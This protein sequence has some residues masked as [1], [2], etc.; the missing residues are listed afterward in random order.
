VLPHSACFAACFE[1]EESF[2]QDKEDLVFGTLVTFDSYWKVMCSAKGGELF[3]RFCVKGFLSSE[4]PVRM[5]GS[6]GQR[7]FCRFAF[8]MHD[9]TDSGHGQAV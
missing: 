5:S 8:E 1:R 2:R 7:F 6:I 9:C 3:V 4:D